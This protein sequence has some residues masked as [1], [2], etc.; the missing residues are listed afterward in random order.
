MTNLHR[1]PG[2]FLE[3]E[4]AEGN[5]R[6]VGLEGNLT[7]VR[8]AFP[9]F[10]RTV[11][12]GERL[13]YLDS[14]ATSQKPKAVIEAVSKYFSQYAANVHRGVYSLS[15]E[16][17]DAYEAVRKTVADFLGVKPSEKGDFPEIIFTSGTTESINLVAHSWGRLNL[18][19][20]DEVVVTRAE[21]HANFVPWQ[22]L[23]IEKK[24]RFTII[25]LDLT[26]RPDSSQWKEAMSRGPK[27][28]AF[29]AL[30]NV[31]GILNP[32]EELSSAAKKA[33]AVVLVDAAQW[34]AHLPIAMDSWKSV[35]FLAFSSHKCLGPTGTGVLFARKRVHAQ[36]QPYQMGGDM[37]RRVD[38]Y[39][40]SFAEAPA[41]FE[42][43]TP[44]VAEVIGM[45]A[46]LQYLQKMGMDAVRQH[47][48]GLLKEF[49]ERVEGWESFEWIGPSV[50]AVPLTERS[51][52]V[53]FSIR[54][55]HPHD[56]A[57][58]LDMRGICIRAGHLCAQ[59]LLRK[60]ETTAVNRASFYVYNTKEDVIALV[61][62]LKA[63]EE[64]FGKRKK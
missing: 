44:A 27:L 62:G 34:A 33:G 22:Q 32:V 2:T 20:G 6:N 58:F 49:A 10:E 14:A 51:G 64:Y 59:P 57:T 52:V 11:H 24:L 25:E 35:D 9:V 3:N 31:L 54:G 4:N 12:G 56:L 30:S 1:I 53:S 42:A 63:A 40:T 19:T 38:D 46:A 50:K 47:E 55:V 26:G 21:H 5:R 16:A 13:V 28:V 41:C 17:T 7:G 15:Q 39:D 45:G 23:A 29:T 8:S 18:H 61:E 43:G 60:L 37:I 48:Q 36:M